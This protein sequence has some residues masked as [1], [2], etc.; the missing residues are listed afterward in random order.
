MVA[1]NA[2]IAITFALSSGQA[3][4]EVEGRELLVGIGPLPVLLYLVMDED[5]EGDETRHW[6]WISVLSR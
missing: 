4:D 2:R 3:A 6:P 1:A 5:Y